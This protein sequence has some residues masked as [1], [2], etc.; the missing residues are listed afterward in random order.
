MSAL[1]IPKEDS[2]I[3]YS[4]I[5]NEESHNFGDA[6]DICCDLMGREVDYEVLHPKSNP[7]VSYYSK[8][9]GNDLSR[10]IVC[11]EKKF[12]RTSLVD[13]KKKVT[14]LEKENSKDNKRTINIDSGVL[15][16]EQMIL[17]TGKP[18]AHRVYLSEGVYADLSYIFQN[19]KYCDL[20]WTY[21][22]Y[23][24]QDKLSFFLKMRQLLKTSLTS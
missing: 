18:Y 7:S 2:F 22:D 19:G 23:K 5:Y 17:A 1:N 24:D 21:P 20:P 4:V 6:L 9:M 14:A 11:F 8:E 16:L 10:F 3:F 12:K 15:S 13:F